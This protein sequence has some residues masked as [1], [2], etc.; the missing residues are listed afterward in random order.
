VKRVKQEVEEKHSPQ[1]PRTPAFLSDIIGGHEAM[2]H[3]HHYVAFVQ[4][5]IGESK[6]RCGGI[7]VLEDFVLTAA[8]CWGR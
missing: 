6:H 3:P 7:L 1:S 8:H 4:F 2:P 5:Q